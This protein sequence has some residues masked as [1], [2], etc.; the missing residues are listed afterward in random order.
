MPENQLDL[1]LPSYPYEGIIPP[2]IWFGD[3]T[4]FMKFL[5]EIHLPHPICKQVLTA[6]FRY[7][8]YIMTA[9]DVFAICPE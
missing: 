5:Y 7:F 3:R 6:Y 4:L 2:E 9:A 8:N 1:P